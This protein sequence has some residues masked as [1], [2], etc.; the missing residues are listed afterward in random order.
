MGA[1]S[2]GAGSA[3][4]LLSAPER[5]TLRAGKRD[6]LTRRAAGPDEPRVAHAGLLHRRMFFKVITLR[7]TRC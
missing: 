1:R 7:S 5:S 2:L 4:M 6:R 3:K